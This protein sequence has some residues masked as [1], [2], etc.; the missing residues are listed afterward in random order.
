MGSKT[1]LNERAEKG[2]VDWTDEPGRNICKPQGEREE[3][4]E[5]EVQC[6]AACLT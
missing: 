5:V 4:M 2:Q 3:E 6:I 1:R